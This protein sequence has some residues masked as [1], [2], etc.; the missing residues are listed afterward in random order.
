MLLKQEVVIEL[1]PYRAAAGLGV[2]AMV[3]MLIQ[4]VGKTMSTLTEKTG[5]VWCASHHSMLPSVQPDMP[6]FF[7]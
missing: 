6:V 3:C 2:V 4:G 1:Y 5:C 7:N